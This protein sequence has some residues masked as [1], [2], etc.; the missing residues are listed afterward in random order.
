[1]GS[2]KSTLLSLIACEMP[3]TAGNIEVSGSIAYVPQ[4]PW[5]IQRFPDR[6]QVVIGERG[7]T[8]SGGQQARVSLARAVYAD[9]DIYLLDNPLA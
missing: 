7:N 1:V 8:L 3:T 5:D 6:D 9:C 2:G 4:I